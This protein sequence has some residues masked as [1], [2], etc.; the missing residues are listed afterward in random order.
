MLVCA[1][2]EDWQAADR[3]TSG[4]ARRGFDVRL[5]SLSVVDLDR[6]RV[7]ALAHAIRD[8][9]FVVVLL[10]PRAVPIP[11]RPV[12]AIAHVLQLVSRLR[13]HALFLIPVRL[14]AFDYGDLGALHLEAID[15]FPD[16]YEAEVAVARSMVA[17]YGRWDL[18]S[19]HYIMLGFGT[20]FLA[21]ILLF[22]SVALPLIFVPDRPI[23]SIL[24]A[25]ISLMVWLY[26]TF[27]ASAWAGN[28]LGGWARR[29]RLQREW[30]WRG[31][32]GALTAVTA[33]LILL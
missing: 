29:H 21:S 23:R 27:L 4:L 31:F 24:V 7:S 12:P 10:S 11:S 28:R 32:L 26:V 8:S 2:A 18:E 33:L 17:N 15:F 22:V 6:T 13:S 9:D 25:G 19:R 20:I 1:V 3:L 14:E 5:Q 30:A 16:P